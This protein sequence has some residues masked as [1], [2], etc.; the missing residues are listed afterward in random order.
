MSQTALASPAQQNWNFG[1]AALCD[2]ANDLRDDT[3]LARFVELRH[4]ATH[5]LVVAH[6]FQAPE[7]T[8]WLERV[9]WPDFEAAS[10]SQLQLARA[11]IN[12]L[13]RAVD[14]EEDTRSQQFEGPLMPLPTTDVDA[15]LSQLD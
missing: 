1:L 8:G 15:D 10:L 5:R 12:Y 13:V 2:L 6:E 14:A 9:S 11:A 7:S 3:P 4:A